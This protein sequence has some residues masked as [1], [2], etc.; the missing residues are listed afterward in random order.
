MERIF[1]DT[2]GNITAEESER[3]GTRKQE[4][5]KIKLRQ[6]RALTQTLQGVAEGI[7]NGG[8]Y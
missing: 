7:L 5:A 4:L 6:N 2:N 3:V 1:L 8:N